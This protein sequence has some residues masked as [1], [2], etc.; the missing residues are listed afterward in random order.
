MSAGACTLDRNTLVNSVLNVLSIWLR[1][2]FGARTTNDNF[3]FFT[4]S[5]MSMSDAKK[6]KEKEKKK[7]KRK[8]KSDRD[9]DA[10]HFY[11]PVV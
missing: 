11:K 3:G 8:R 9:R 7:G 10:R 6:E 4:G 2:N 5:G 1:F